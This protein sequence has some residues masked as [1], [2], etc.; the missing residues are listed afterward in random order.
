MFLNP[1]DTIAC[2]KTVAVVVPS[3]DIFPAR[4]ATSLIICAPMF[5]RVSSR[6]SIAS[7]TVT[8]SLVTNG[9]CPFFTI[10]T[11][12]PF[13]PIVTDTASPRVSTPRFNPA[14][15]LFNTTSIYCAFF[16]MY[17]KFLSDTFM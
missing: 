2:A 5:S 8:P 16:D 10:T 11:L 1:S 15:V 9:F 6:S 17:F 13:G 7:A 12:R 4:V 3:P 14:N